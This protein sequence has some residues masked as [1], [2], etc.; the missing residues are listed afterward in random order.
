LTAKAKKKLLI[1]GALPPPIHGATVYFATLLKTKVATEFD[2]VLLDLKFADSIGGYGRFSP[3][4]IMRL[5]S[6]VMRLC[7]VLITSRVDLVYAAMSFNRVSFAKD[8]LLVATC[9]LFGRRVVGCILGIGLENLYDR[10][11]WFMKCFISWGVGLY[12]AFVTPSLKMHE[13]YFAKLLPL[14]KARSVPFGIFTDAGVPIRQ[15]RGDSDSARLVFY[16][17]FIKSKGIDEVLKAIPLVRQKNPNVSFLFVGAWDSDA[18]KLAAM[19]LVESTGI[20]EWVKF[21]GVVSGDGKKACLQESDIFLLPT[22]YP[23]EGLPL[24]ILEAMSYG[25][26]IIST[27]HAAITV[28]LED[29]VDGLICRPRDPADLAL[30]INPLIED[31]HLLLSMQQNSIRKFREAFMAERF[32]ESLASELLSLCNASQSK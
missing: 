20:A 18:H 2:V 21:R 12:H 26:A 9:R 23:F 27:D 29:G 25:C 16:S 10:S 13:R 1:L 30:K 32:G 6:Y 24:A 15:L 3:A 8:I 31:K 28:A 5:V 19:N 11:G 4:K 17:N 22:Y 7:W 14:Q